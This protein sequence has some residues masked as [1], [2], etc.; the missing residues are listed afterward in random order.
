MQ[1]ELLPVS[2]HPFFLPLSPFLFRLSSPRRSEE[3]L[4]VGAKWSTI[5][6]KVLWLLWCGGS[7]GS[8]LCD[9]FTYLIWQ[10]MMYILCIHPSPY[11]LDLGMPFLCSHQCVY[12]PFL[13]YLD[14][15]MSFLIIA[16]LLSRNDH[17]HCSVSF[18]EKWL[19][20]SM[21][22]GK[23]KGQDWL[24]WSSWCMLCMNSR[25]AYESTILNVC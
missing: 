25:W 2:Q 6:C 9:R 7:W 10:W 12:R 11:N 4:R 19:T 17:N 13:N 8:W 5:C 24:L 22:K 3:V 18:D 21:R 23:E 15:G 16:F 14:L 20:N 1:R